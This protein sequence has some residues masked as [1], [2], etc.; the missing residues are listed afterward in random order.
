MS[1]IGNVQRQS[2][3]AQL[4]KCN[5]WAGLFCWSSSEVEHLDSGTHPGAGGWTLPTWTDYTSSI[6]SD[7]W[8]RVK[9]RHTISGSDDDVFYSQSD[10][11]EIN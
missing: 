4:H 2:M 5:S 7:G 1:C 8:Y 11:I 9:T 6:L 10:W 3:V